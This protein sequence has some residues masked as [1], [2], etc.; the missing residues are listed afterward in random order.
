ME[1]SRG[2]QKNGYDVN[3]AKLKDLV[4]YLDSSDRRLILCSKNTVACLNIRG[5]MV[6]GTALAATKFRD[7]LYA[8]YDFTPP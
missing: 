8:R 6:T 2:R 7:L 1:E 5:T 4:A 3:D